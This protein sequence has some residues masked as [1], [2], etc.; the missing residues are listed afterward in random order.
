MR[1]L[2]LAFASRC[3]M[4]VSRKW[5]LAVVTLHGVGHGLKLRPERVE[6]HFRFLARH[7]RLILPSQL[8]RTA[9]HRRVAM[10]TI[11]D[12]R[13][14]VYEHIFPIAKAARIPISICL[15]TDFFFRGE[16]LWFDKLSWASARA[17]P[18][19]TA[20]VDGVALRGGDA[21][22]FDQLRLRLKQYDPRRRNAA[23]EEMFSQLSL[24]PPPS[25]PREYRPLT[26]LE[27]EEMLDSGLAEIVGHAATH[28]VATALSEADLRRE[29]KESKEE[30][31]DFCGQRLTA[32]CYPNGM[33]GH[34]DSVTGEAV[35]KAGF[36]MAF[37]SIE[38]T[39]PLSQLDPFALKRV[40][41]HPRQ[42]VF[43]KLCSGLGDL[44]RKLSHGAREGYC[45]S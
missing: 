41:A 32:F 35:K 1:D 45:R 40:H 34:F 33:R 18:G 23:I 36:Q 44:Q 30:L 2:L 4:L 27:M 16:W 43:E 10:V 11:D 42:A 39:N 6:Q 9:G 7:Y 31:E 22:G 15:P 13:A 37:T 25:P 38:G 20:E 14:D 5:R 28:T 26:A 24:V 8:A 12:G 19:T 29:L 3:Y 21:R 17:D